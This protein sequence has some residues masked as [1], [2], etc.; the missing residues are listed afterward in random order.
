MAATKTKT[1]KQC[2]SEMPAKAKRCAACGARTTGSVYSSVG[3]VIL[4]L[5]AV[6]IILSTLPYLK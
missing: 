4:A 3:V 1:C 6:Y 5:I 2:M